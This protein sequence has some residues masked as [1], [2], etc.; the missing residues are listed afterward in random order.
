MARLEN[1]QPAALPALPVDGMVGE[2]GLLLGDDA[3][4]QSRGAGIDQALDFVRRGGGDR[5]RCYGEQQ[6]DDFSKDSNRALQ[7][8]ACPGCARAA[9]PL[10]IFSLMR[11]ALPRRSR[12]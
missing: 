5:R 11:A 6:R 9:S 1:S 12:R 4:R 8:R 10:Q 7:A 2:L 3:Q